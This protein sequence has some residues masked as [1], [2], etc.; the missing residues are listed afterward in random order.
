MDTAAAWVSAIAAVFSAYIAWRMLRIQ[1]SRGVDPAPAPTVPPAEVTPSAGTA[2]VPQW[3]T[4]PGRRWKWWLWLVLMILALLIALTGVFVFFAVVARAD[5]N[6]IAVVPLALS[7][8][9]SGILLGSLVR[10][11]RIVA[12]PLDLAI[13]PVGLRRREAGRTWLVRWDEV[14]RVAVRRVKAN[15]AILLWTA[16]GT[17]YP[18]INSIL[19]P[20]GPTW[21]PRK[22]AVLFA[23]TKFHQGGAHAISAAIRRYAGTRWSEK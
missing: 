13:G 15:R 20:V 1:Q 6:G 3:T 16:T 19:L 8:V 12:N 18:S 11:F 21:V 17:E 5:G 14:H 2:P 7:I 9:V 22:R 23:W 10:C 4:F